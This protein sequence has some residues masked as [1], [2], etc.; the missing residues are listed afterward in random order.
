VEDLAPGRSGTIVIRGTVD[1]QTE[2]GPFSNGAQIATTAWETG[3]LP[4]QD[5]VASQV[6]AGPP[7][8]IQVTG[9]PTQIP[10]GGSVSSIEAVITDL[11]GNPVADGT[12]VSFITDRGTLNPSTTTSADGLASTTLTSGPAAG[13]ATVTAAAGDAQGTAQVTVLPGPPD[14]LQLSADPTQIPVGG[15]TS[16]LTARVYDQFDN[17]VAD[18]TAVSF[19]TSKGSIA[20]TQMTTLGGLAQTTLTSGSQSGIAVVTAQAGN[21]STSVTVAMWLESHRL[22]FPLFV[23]QGSAIPWKA[24]R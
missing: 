11:W 19:S 9:T 17:A 15:Y 5:S 12:T 18:G 4:N 14:S 1:E 20:P 21:T 16:T 6:V 8:L 22:W 24:T 3:T 7:A 2:L 10:V 13:V 23:S